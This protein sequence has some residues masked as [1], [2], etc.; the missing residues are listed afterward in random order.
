M[1]LGVTSGS[2]HYNIS[3]VSPVEVSAL[4]SIFRKITK[5]HDGKY[6]TLTIQKI[7]KDANG[8][9]ATSSRNIRV[10]VTSS[11]K[12]T[13]TQ[14]MQDIYNK[15]IRVEA[16]ERRLNSAT[17]PEDE[18]VGVEARA[19]THYLS[20]ESLKKHLLETDLLTPQEKIA[21]RSPL[22]NGSNLPD[23]LNNLS[24]G[25]GGAANSSTATSNNQVSQS[26][27]DL[28]TQSLL[29]GGDGLPSIHF[30]YSDQ[31]A[32]PHQMDLNSFLETL[33][34]QIV[35]SGLGS[36]GFGSVKKGVFEGK[37]VAI[38]RLEDPE[39]IDKTHLAG[40]GLG[41]CLSEKKTAGLFIK[42]HFIIVDIYKNDIYAPDRNPEIFEDPIERKAITHQGDLYRLPSNSYIVA[43]VSDFA[44]TPIPNNLVVD[45][46]KAIN[47]GRQAA[48]ALSALH[49]QGIVHHDFKPENCLIDEK[50]KV[51][52]I[53]PGLSVYLGKSGKTNSSMGT[54]GYFAPEITKPHDYKVDSWA[55]G[56]TLLH[57]LTGQSLDSRVYKLKRALRDIKDEITAQNLEFNKLKK[58]VEQK[59]KE[60]MS[61]KDR[62]ELEKEMR[63][64]EIEYKRELMVAEKTKAAYEAALKNSSLM[65]FSM[66]GDLPE[67]FAPHKK[68]LSNILAGLLTQDP[69][70]RMSAREAAKR[71]SAIETKLQESSGSHQGGGGGAG[72]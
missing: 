1:A 6:I 52:L 18:G 40:E 12:D 28:A 57:L 13:K 4:P 8:T 42:Y 44:G 60:R 35:G 19:V 33:G 49:D 47:I 20:P 36:G 26:I 67:T 63:G 39:P 2:F 27:A 14:R 71:L 66:L 38:K 22:A 72:K 7:I 23:F 53:D 32:Q 3:S 65:V 64:L 55:F 21:L 41:I 24:S 25:G 62:Q 54:R 50:G 9:E 17:R 58:G 5:R 30:Q 10:R 43:T 34:V 16:S 29:A 45:S 56:V 48:E 31:L 59:L 68:E 70:S 37:Q 46:L 15:S 51:R 61:P 11:G 69:K